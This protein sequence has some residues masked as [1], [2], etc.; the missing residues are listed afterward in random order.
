MN[1]FYCNY[2][3]VI[4]DCAKVTIGDRVALGPNVSIYAATHSTDVGERLEELERAYPV[5]IGDDVWIGGS[6]TIVCSAKGTRIGN[7]CA[8][9]AGTTL[10]GTFPDVS[11]DFT[12]WY[13]AYAQ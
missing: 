8:V 11:V 7:G 12:S 2:N 5:E 3:T 13:H 6:V 9:A 1:S 10:W 4:L